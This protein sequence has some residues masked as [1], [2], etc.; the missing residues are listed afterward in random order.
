MWLKVLKERQ[1][2]VCGC[3]LLS[4]HAHSQQ[5]SC[6]HRARSELTFLP[7]DAYTH[8]FHSLALGQSGA[9]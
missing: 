8:N 6:I 9:S 2:S 7:R 5:Q 3:S 4:E 1:V